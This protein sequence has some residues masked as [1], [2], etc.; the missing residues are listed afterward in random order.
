M[1]TKSRNTTGGANRR[2]GHQPSFSSTP[3]IRIMNFAT[4]RIQLRRKEFEWAPAACVSP[5]ITPFSQ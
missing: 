5:H 4:R 3:P 2:P 1:R